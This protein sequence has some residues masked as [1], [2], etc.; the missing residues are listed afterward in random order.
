MNNLFLFYVCCESFE[1]CVLLLRV[2]KHLKNSLNIKMIE[3][4]VISYFNHH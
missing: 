3:F 2:M 1:R 4:V